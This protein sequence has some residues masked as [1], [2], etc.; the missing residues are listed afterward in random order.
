M[1]W[2]FSISPSHWR[3]TQFNH[4]NVVCHLIVMVRVCVCAQIGTHALYV[5]L[6]QI[7]MDECKC[8]LRIM[9]SFSICEQ[10]YQKW[11]MTPF[12]VRKIDWTIVWRWRHSVS[13]ILHPMVWFQLLLFAALFLLL[14][15]IRI[16]SISDAT[17]RFLSIYWCECVC[18]IPSH[19]TAK[20]IVLLRNYHK[21]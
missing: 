3:N 11:P 7:P 20:L 2:I 17:D 10:S 1:T 21:A 6:S 16:R 15:F 8:P 4:F 14:S 9:P 12:S 5:H 13:D 19:C 18:F